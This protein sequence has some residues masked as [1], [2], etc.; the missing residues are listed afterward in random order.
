M[1]SSKS[2]EPVS[3]KKTIERRL[4]KRG[5][6]LFDSSSNSTVWDPSHSKSAK[7][8]SSMIKP[9]ISKD[10]INNEM[11]SEQSTVPEPIPCSSKETLV[12]DN[13]AKEIPSK[14]SKLS[15]LV[16]YGSDES[17]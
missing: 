8:L 3:A 15:N 17:D 5:P 2:S 9:K 12:K 6:D 13:S 10:A 11:S 4:G 14:I 1:Y 16:D 7:V